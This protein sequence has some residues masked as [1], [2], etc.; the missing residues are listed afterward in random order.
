MSGVARAFWQNGQHT[1]RRVLGAAFSAEELKVF[2]HEKFNLERSTWS[3]TVPNELA[4]ELIEHLQR[5]YGDAGIDALLC[6]ALASRSGR[7]DLPELFFDRWKLPFSRRGEDDVR[8]LV[9]AA[10]GL[11]DEARKDD[12]EMLRRFVVECAARFKT[13]LGELGVGLPPAWVRESPANPWS[14]ADVLGALAPLAARRKMN[15]CHPLGVFMTWLGHRPD[16]PS[17]LT[18]AWRERVGDAMW[19]KLDATARALEKAPSVRPGERSPDTVRPPTLMVIVRGPTGDRFVLRARLSAD[20]VSRWID[21]PDAVR[22]CVGTGAVA[23]CVARIRR[24]A[25]RDLDAERHPDLRVEVVLPRR[26]F[27]EAIECVEVETSPLDRCALGCLGPVMIR[28]L[29]RME[30]LLSTSRAEDDLLYETTHTWKRRWQKLHANRRRTRGDRTVLTLHDEGAHTDERI[31]DELASEERA[32]VVSKRV[33][34]GDPW[35][36]LRQCVDR[37]VP[38][39]VWPRRESDAT[40][41]VPEVIRA[42]HVLA[43]PERTRDHRKQ[44]GVAALLWDDPGHLPPAGEIG[45]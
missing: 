2:A 20:G 36:F 22:E 45:F 21:L 17:G 40:K 16:A 43:L 33:H 5:R 6:R 25:L 29:E 7:T 19:S 42:A 37:G 13:H 24:H 30:A 32:C 27:S 41:A 28:Y 18:E 34:G 12:G 1:L 38:V 39:V 35:P 10:F 23:A 4:V 11:I 31:R 15:G 8:M 9:R 44:G 3:K 26:L 14:A